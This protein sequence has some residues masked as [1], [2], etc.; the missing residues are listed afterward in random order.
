MSSAAKLHPRPQD[1]TAPTTLN[2]LPKLL[3]T[4]S[5]LAL[6]E[7][8]GAINQPHDAEGELVPDVEIGRLDF[9]DHDPSAPDDAAGARR[10]HMYIGQHQRLA[11]E[12]RKLPKAIAVVRRRRGGEAGE[13]GDDLEVVEIVKHKLLFSNRPEPVGTAPAP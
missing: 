3:Q 8:Q 7:L 13:Q 4:P 1:A 9:P 12:V 5:G 10:V 2:P 6:L 11:G